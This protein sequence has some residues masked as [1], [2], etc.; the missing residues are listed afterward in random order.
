MSETETKDYVFFDIPFSPQTYRKL[1]ELA[2]S[3]R[4]TSLGVLQQL[5]DGYSRNGT[6]PIPTPTAK[7]AFCGVPVPHSMLR[8]LKFMEA[9][10]GHAVSALTY[11]RAIIEAELQKK[12]QK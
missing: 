11:L 12:P 5:V 1:S 8:E 9:E 3:R 10:S 4:T 6:P 2:K 7:D